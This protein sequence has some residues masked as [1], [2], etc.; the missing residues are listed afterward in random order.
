MHIRK[1]DFNHLEINYSTQ[2]KNQSN[3]IA[4]QV[5]RGHSKIERERDKDW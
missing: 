5:E 4:A 3:P 2:S 1:K